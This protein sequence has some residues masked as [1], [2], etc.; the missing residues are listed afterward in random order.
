MLFGLQ[1]VIA[2]A[3]A[4]LPYAARRVGR[5]DLAGLRAGFRQ[6]NIAASVYSVV[7]LWPLMWLTAPWLADRLA[8][9][10]VK[11]SSVGPPYRAVLVFNGNGGNRSFR[12]PLAARLSG[13]RNRGLGASTAR[14]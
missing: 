13:H 4:I 10:F 14:C 1:P 5:G 2:I 8:G 6:A 12:A 9:W 7:V 3:V 11:P